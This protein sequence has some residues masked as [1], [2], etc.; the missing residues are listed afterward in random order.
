MRP[1]LMVLLV[2][3]LAVHAQSGRGP[4][5]PGYPPSL[6]AGCL[7]PDD[8]IDLF[9]PG[10]E[11]YGC[12]KIPTLLRH[13]NGTLVAIIEARKFSCDDHGYVDLR[14]RRSHDD[15]FTWEKSRLVHGY[16][17][18]SQWTTV[19]DAN[20]VEVTKRKKIVS[21]IIRRIML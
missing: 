8:Q 7:K 3:Q 10:D 6:K 14:L 9:C 16:S 15:G 12:Y 20:V 17:T 19:G 4:T 18:P 2:A 1:P 13:T 5:P 11:Q 21:L